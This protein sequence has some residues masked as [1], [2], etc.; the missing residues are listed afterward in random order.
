[1]ETGKQIKRI[2]NVAFWLVLTVFICG[3]LTIAFC[4]GI[5]SGQWEG[6]LEGAFAVIGTSALGF[7]CARI[8]KALLFGFAQ[9]VDDTEAI[10]KTNELILESTTGIPKKEA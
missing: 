4:V 7:L 8:A 5:G 9:L 10:R 1:M 3:G 2:A 6:Y